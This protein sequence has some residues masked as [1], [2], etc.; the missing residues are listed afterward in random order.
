M[1]MC[2]LVSS[3]AVY[4]CFSNFISFDEPTLKGKLYVWGSLLSSLS[5]FCEDPSRRQEIVYFVFVRAARSAYTLAK[6]RG[7][8]SLPF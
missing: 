8:P 5:I 1:F 4:N 3:I 7:L 2:T 6:K